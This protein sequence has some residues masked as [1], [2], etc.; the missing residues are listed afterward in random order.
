MTFDP[1]EYSLVIQ[2]VDWLHHTHCLKKTIKTSKKTALLT[3]YVVSKRV[4][5]K[6]SYVWT[7]WMCRLT[8]TPLQEW[9]W[10]ILG[11]KKKHFCVALKWNFQIFGSVGPLNHYVFWFFKHSREH[12]LGAFPTIFLK[13][14]VKKT[15]NLTKIGCIPYPS[16]PPHL[17]MGQLPRATWHFIFLGPMLHRVEMLRLFSNHR[18]C[19]W[20]KAACMHV[21]SLRSVMTSWGDQNH[22][23]LWENII[24]LTPF[25][26][27]YH[28]PPTLT[29]SGT[30]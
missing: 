6:K 8:F 9:M 24:H 16:P 1:C 12:N 30:A 7:M 18:I 26:S 3:T 17:V 14:N 20:Y 21:D 4:S 19:S 15:S 13:T 5:H 22:H 10:C 29:L 27:C 28:W 11:Q 2:T 25:L 23:L